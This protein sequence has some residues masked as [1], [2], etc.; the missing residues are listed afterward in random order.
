MKELVQLGGNYQLKDLIGQTLV[1]IAAANGF[2][3]ILVYLCMVLRMPYDETEMNSRTPLHLAALENQPS[4]GML[5]I[6][7]TDNLDQQDI[8]GFTALHLSALSQCYKM[9]RNLIIMGASKEITD[10][11]N[12][13]PLDIALSRSDIPI[14]KLLVIPI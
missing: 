10:F 6:S 9:V 1:H 11:K 14:I 2:E 7:M 8:E 13:K 3:G 4:T 5:L 12:Q